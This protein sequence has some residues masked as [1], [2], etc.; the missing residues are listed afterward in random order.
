MEG[1]GLQVRPRAVSHGEWRPCC[2]VR[3]YNVVERAL[4]LGPG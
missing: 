4:A 2:S 1:E 3:L